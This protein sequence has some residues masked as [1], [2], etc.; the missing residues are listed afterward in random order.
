MRTVAILPVKRFEQAKQRLSVP[1]R[2]SLAATMAGKVM[3]ALAEARSL[4]GVLVVTGDETAADGARQLAFDVVPEPSVDGHVAA[5]LLGIERARVLGARRVLLVP[6]DCP[7]LSG[8]DVDA[9]LGRHDGPGVVVVPDRH[10]T[11]TNALLLEPPG[12][13]RP[14]FGPGSRERH[15]RLAAAAGVRCTVDDVPSLAYDVDTAE[16]YAVLLERS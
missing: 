12:A 5:A 6:G 15:E 4:D 14:A 13:I 3:N 2:S 7:L 9:L 1:A 11:G 8:A 16:D 10:G